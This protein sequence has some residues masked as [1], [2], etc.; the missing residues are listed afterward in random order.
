VITT[1]GEARAW[2]RSQ[3]NKPNLIKVRGFLAAIAQRM[4]KADRREG[5]NLQA[6]AKVLRE[7]LRR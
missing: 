3:G 1:A 7:A 6:A 5:K 2:V 4:P